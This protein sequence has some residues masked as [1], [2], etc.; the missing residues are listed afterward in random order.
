MKI[1]LVAVVAL[2]ALPAT[3][4][5]ATRIWLEYNGQQYVN[6]QALDGSLPLD[7]M[8]DFDYGDVYTVSGGLYMDSMASSVTISEVTYAGL[9]FPPWSF[10]Y[11]TPVGSNLSQHIDFGTLNFGSVGELLALAGP[12]KYATIVLN[13]ASLTPG[14]YHIM[15]GDSASGQL[16]GV[17]YWAGT[18]APLGQEGEATP[19]DEVGT[20]TLTIDQ[21]ALSVA[22]G[23]RDV[24]AL[25]GST[26]F[27]V[28]N[29]GGGLLDYAVV[30]NPADTWLT[31]ASGGT[32]TC[33]PDAT[34]TVSYSQNTGIARVGTITVTAAGATGSPT[35]VTVTQAE[36]STALA[37]DS[38]VSMKTHGTCGTYA[39]ASGGVECRKNQITRVATVFNQAIQRV[40]NNN[41]DISVTSGSIST[42]TIG[43]TT[44]ANDTLIVDMTAGTVT[45][46]A[47]WTLSYPGIAA[48]CDI[49]NRTT[50]TKCW[51]VVSGDVDGNGTVQNGDVT[52]VVGRLGQVVTD[53]LTARRDYDCNGRIQNSDVTSVVGRLGGALCTGCTCSP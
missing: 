36:C 25:A 10:D 35:S 8:V 51:K 52:S 16:S 40:N 53:L 4:W 29:A 7:V 3:V 5:G 27:T 50:A 45:N 11:G 41:T 20:F 2:L 22:P 42:I 47:V 26:S 44:V 38:A 34:I 30:V 49:N 17:G 15:I 9:V 14:V 32:G 28:S 37:I 24:G 23:N 1:K 31:I 43:T 46:L 33:P 48:V 6:G 19:F 13:I 21:Q 39:I 18:N 12:Q